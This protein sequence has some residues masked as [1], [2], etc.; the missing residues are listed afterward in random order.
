MQCFDLSSLSRELSCV[1]SLGQI[2]LVMLA[3]RRLVVALPD[4]VG[5]SLHMA[6]EHSSGVHQAIEVLPVLMLGP[7]L[8]LVRALVPLPL[9]R[10]EA[11][12]G[13]DDAGVLCDRFVQV[14]SLKP[15]VTFGVVVV[16]VRAEQ[17]PPFGAAPT[18]HAH[19]QDVAAVVLYGEGQRHKLIGE[20]LRVVP[21]RQ[22]LGLSPLLRRQ[23]HLAIRNVNRQP[24]VAKVLDQVAH[25]LDLDAHVVGE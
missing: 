10:T 21:F 1:Q 5:N 15:L 25:P 6:V 9:H 8:G 2:G 13:V 14:L 3:D 7:Q 20:V 24:G 12:A 23:D 4:H 16:N 22:P 19:G 11:V 17:E 18:G